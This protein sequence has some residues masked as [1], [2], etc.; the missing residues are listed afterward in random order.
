MRNASGVMNRVYAGYEPYRG[1]IPGRRTGTMISAVAHERE[2]ALAVHARL[3]RQEAEGGYLVM[4][5][6]PR[7]QRRAIELLRTE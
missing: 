1:D 4:T 6:E 3:Q 5:V 7:W 2:E